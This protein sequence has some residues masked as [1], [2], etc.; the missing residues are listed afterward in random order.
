MTDSDPT[1]SVIIPV[2]NDPE[3]LETTVESLLGQS[4]DDYEVIIADNGSTDRT[5]AL[6]TEYAARERVRCVVEDDI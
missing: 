1:T 5:R 3:G 6:A 4:A 2:Y